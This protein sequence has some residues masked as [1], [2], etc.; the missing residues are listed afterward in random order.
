MQKGRDVPIEQHPTWA[1]VTAGASIVTKVGQKKN[2][3]L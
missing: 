1:Y 3:Y 2:A